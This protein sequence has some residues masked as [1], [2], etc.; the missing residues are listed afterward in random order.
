[1]GISP[2][3]WNQWVCHPSSSPLGTRRSFKR[4]S[5]PIT[6]CGGAASDALWL[7]CIWGAIRADQETLNTAKARGNMSKVGLFFFLLEGG[8]GAGS[9]G[10]LRNSPLLIA[11]NCP[12]PCPIIRPELPKAPDSQHVMQ[13]G[14]YLQVS[15]AFFFITLLNP[16]FNN[17]IIAIIV[18]FHEKVSAPA[19][20]SLLFIFLSRSPPPTC[21]SFQPSPTEQPVYF[22][23][24]HKTCACFQN[25]DFL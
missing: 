11:A 21:P 13:L 19:L 6:Q 25:L 16:Q 20:P 22:K 5:R 3:Q 8:W 24:C 7:Q 23:L 2:Q 14:S 12:L 18:F 1:M 9:G 15:P 10:P 17:I 4:G